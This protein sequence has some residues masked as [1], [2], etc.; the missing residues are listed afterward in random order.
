MDSTC[1]VLK[2]RYYDSCHILKGWRKTEDGLVLQEFKDAPPKRI[3]AWRGLLNRSEQIRYAGQK[4]SLWAMFQQSKG[5]PYRYNLN[6][7][8]LRIGLI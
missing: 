3:Y 8:R 1:A 6:A 4:G 5:T 7:P 2:G